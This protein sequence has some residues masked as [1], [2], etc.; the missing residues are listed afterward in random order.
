MEVLLPGIYP[1][2]REDIAAAKYSALVN[3]LTMVGTIVGMYN[4]RA[5][6]GFL[7][8]TFHPRAF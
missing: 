5:L 2:P 6:I 8:F 1:N 7:V 3:A 4:F